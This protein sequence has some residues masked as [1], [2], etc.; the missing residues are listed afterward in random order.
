MS[1]TFLK[2]EK[3]FKSQ[4]SIQP[5]TPKLKVK[6]TLLSDFTIGKKLGQGRFG[7]VWIAIHKQ[8]GAI[9]ALKKLSKSNIKGN[10]MIDQFILEVKTQSFM[11]SPYIVKIFGI[12]D[13]F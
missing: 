3:S 2:T 13:D 6:K 5:S 9:F 8:T 12:F 1:T 7:V 11:D 10:L 4:L